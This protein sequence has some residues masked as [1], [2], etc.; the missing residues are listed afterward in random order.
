MDRI[1]CEIPLD[2][3]PTVHPGNETS[4]S[5]NP[6]TDTG[7]QQ[8]KEDDVLS[9]ETYGV[10]SVHPPVQSQTGQSDRPV[11]KDCEE[12][13]LRRFYWA[14]QE[15]EVQTVRRGLDAGVDVKAKRTWGGLSDLTSLRVASQSGRTQVAK[16]LI[17]RGADLE[18]RD[19]VDQNTSLHE[20]AGG[21]HTGICELLIRHGA[22]VTARNK[23][24]NTPLHRA[25]GMGHT[26]TCDILI[27]HGADVMARGEGQNTPL[28]RAALVGHSRSCELLIRH[29]ADVMAR[30]EVQNTPLHR[31]AGRGDPETCE[32]LILHGADV[33]AK[34]KNGRIPFDLAKGEK[35]R[36]TLKNQEEKVNQEKLYHELLQKSG[37]V[38]TDRCKVFVF[39]KGKAGKST[40]K[41][42]LQRV[43]SNFI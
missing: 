22:D 28:H 23:V 37:G 18:A 6:A 1:S 43:S 42:S 5:E 29:G 12:M 24:Q 8:D 41:I 16:L 9:E 20:A 40:L 21:G 7:G 33:M 38:K 39:G 14:V 34:N 31:A 35:T 15:G 32:L 3:L 26:R 2:K 25:A 30:D 10:N 13:D 4:N 17:L 19:G 27:R 36:R 11:V